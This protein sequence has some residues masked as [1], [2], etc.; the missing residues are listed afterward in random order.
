MG[1]SHCF[2]KIQ[3]KVTSFSETQDPY[4]NRVEVLID[5]HLDHPGGDSTENLS[6]F[7][8]PTFPI[9]A[10]SPALLSCAGGCSRKLEAREQ[11]LPLARIC[12]TGPVISTSKTYPRDFLPRTPDSGPFWK[13]QG[14]KEARKYVIC[15]ASSKL[16]SSICTVFVQWPHSPSIPL[17]L[18]QLTRPLPVCF[19]WNPGFQGLIWMQRRRGANCLGPRVSLSLP[20]L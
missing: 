4:Q 7:P 15:P 9:C 11:C 5:F 17:C 2:L 18:S 6:T 16:V 14:P 1:E 13:C 20:S 8:R 10:S 19:P 3:S 12:R